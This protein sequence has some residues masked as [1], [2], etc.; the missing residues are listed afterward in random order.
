MT[1]GAESI[2]AIKGV[3]VVIDRSKCVGHGRCYSLAPDVYTCDDEGFV[4]LVDGD[5]VTTLE[6]V[7]QARTGAV[8]C[9]ERALSIEEL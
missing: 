1:A 9:P 6:L 3:R 5:T 7:K 4:E 2:A 8:N